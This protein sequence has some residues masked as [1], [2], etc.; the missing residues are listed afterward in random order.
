[1]IQS[2]TTSLCLISLWHL[3][4]TDCNT[5]LCFDILLTMM[6]LGCDSS[7]MQDVPTLHDWPLVQKWIH[8]D[9]CRKVSASMTYGCRFPSTISDVLLCTQESFPL[10]ALYGKYLLLPSADEMVSGFISHRISDCINNR[11]RLANIHNTC[12]IYR[13]IS[14]REY[15]TINWW[16]N[17]PVR[18]T[19]ATEIL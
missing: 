2:L 19:A 11:Q 16:L 13:Q 9:A 1:M 8:I 10:I 6:Q 12:L 17:V 18:G 5:G 7:L 4:P 14:A 15:F 3:T